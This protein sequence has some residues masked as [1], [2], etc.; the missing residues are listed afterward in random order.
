MSFRSINMQLPCCIRMTF[1]MC[2][3]RENSISRKF[4]SILLTSALFNLQK[5]SGKFDTLSGW[6]LALLKIKGSR[7]DYN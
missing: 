6:N 2:I 3:H 1:P 7:N 5:N 4:L